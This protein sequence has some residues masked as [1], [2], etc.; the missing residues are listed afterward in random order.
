[1]TTSLYVLRNRA[2]ATVS[3]HK[4]LYRALD[5]VGRE[6]GRYDAWVILEME[7]PRL[8]NARRVAEGRGQAWRPAGAT[9]QELLDVC[10]AAEVCQAAV[11]G[12]SDG[13]PRL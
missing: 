3:Q 8:R 12:R 1:M 9:A 2:T 10:G 5:A 4:D 6:I 13:A 7:A 11:L